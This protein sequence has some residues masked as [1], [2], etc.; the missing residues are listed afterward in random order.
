MQK[1]IW[2]PL[3]VGWYKCDL[4]VHVRVTGFKP[5]TISVY[6]EGLVR[7]ATEKFDLSNLQNR[8]AHLTASSISQ[9][10]ASYEQVKE[11]GG[12]GCKWTLSRCFLYLC[13]CGVDRRPPWPKIS[14]V[15]ILTMLWPSRPRPPSRPTASS[16]LD[17]IF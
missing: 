8:Y 16:S 14:H 11:V 12:S 4:R 1:Y 13:S 9:S 15:V 7:F 5:L 17:W 2:H 10:G 3:L 6:R